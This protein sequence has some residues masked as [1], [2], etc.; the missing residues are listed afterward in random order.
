M[1]PPPSE[2]L[3]TR[4]FILDKAKSLGQGMLGDL[5]KTGMGML[6]QVK[7]LGMSTLNQ[8]K[9]N[10][11]GIQQNMM[12]TVFKMFNSLVKLTLLTANASKDCLTT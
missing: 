7:G 11:K 9:G 6:G 3:L 10:L 1:S 5:Q 4:I 8:F 2:Y 12:K